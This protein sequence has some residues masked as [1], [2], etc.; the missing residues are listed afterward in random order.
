MTRKEELEQKADEVVDIVYVRVDRD[1][2]LDG[3]SRLECINKISAVLLQVER[4][5]LVRVT[6]E[7]C[8]KFHEYTNYPDSFG[9]WVRAQQQELG[10]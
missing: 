4:E 8:A 10:S 3:Y 5:V 7:Y 9:D 1:G 2:D 6:K